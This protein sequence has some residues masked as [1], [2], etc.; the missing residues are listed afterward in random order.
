M[1][2]TLLL[3]CLGT[4]LLGGITGFLGVFPFLRQQS[5]LGD[6]LSHAMLPGIACAF[7]ISKSCHGSML[8]IGAIFMGLLTALLFTLLEQHTRLK[9]D[10]LLGILLSTF[11]GLGILLIT[12]IQKKAYA[13]SAVIQRFFFGNASTITYDDIWIITVIGALCISVIIVL[14][15]EIQLFL[16]DSVYAHSLG[17]P[18]FWI[19]RL[20]MSIFVI[21]LA[22]GLQIAGV[23][24]MSSF[25]IAPVAAARQ[26]I[27]S[28]PSLC[29]ASASIGAVSG[30]FGALISYY[31][32]SL[33]TG[34]TI[35]ICLTASVFFSLLFSPSRG[36]LRYWCS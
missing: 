24:L 4:F 14:W 33:P 11:F 31:H 25:L 23:I 19:E 13:H 12:I 30:V 34:P 28:V 27:R 2:V 16:F 17:Y 7:L 5:L 36:I 10:A 29:I 9:R 35:V 18:V 15:K 1:T 26:W 8:L 22:L 32:G 3:V 20:L 21:T 6:A